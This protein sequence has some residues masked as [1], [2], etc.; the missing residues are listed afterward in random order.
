M[1]WHLTRARTS[2]PSGGH[3]AR[4]HDH[5]I[6]SIYPFTPEEVEQLVTHSNECV[7]MWATKDGW[8]VGVTHAFV[9]KDGQFWITFAAHRHRAQSRRVR[10]ARRQSARPG[11]RR[12]ARARSRDHRPGGA[13][14]RRQGAHGRAACRTDG[15][16]SPDAEDR[17]AVPHGGDT[18]RLA[19]VA[20]AARPSCRSARVSRRC[21]TG[22]GLR[23]L[24]QRKRAGQAAR[25]GSAC[26]RR[27]ITSGSAT[28]G[29][30]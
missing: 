2:G 26:A 23:L 16:G 6:V 30:R 15:R 3:M 8:P 13:R 11:N 7:L 24:R 21:G 29:R 14:Y 25:R 10:C 9:W 5:E 17:G 20:G 1:N 28:T 22:L 19:P 27:S 12:A 4:A 18:A